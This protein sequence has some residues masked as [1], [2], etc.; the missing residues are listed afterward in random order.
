[1]TIT[2]CVFSWQVSL[3]SEPSITIINQPTLLMSGIFVP[4]YSLH[5]SST[6]EAVI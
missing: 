4:D 3:L 1:M 2:Y 5:I 6:Q